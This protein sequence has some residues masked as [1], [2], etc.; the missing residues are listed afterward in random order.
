MTSDLPVLL[1]GVTMLSALHM[2]N[3]K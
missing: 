3:V 1:A 2:G